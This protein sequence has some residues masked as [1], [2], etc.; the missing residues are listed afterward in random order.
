MLQQKVEG[1][2]LW[3]TG[4]MVCH[5]P[6]SLVTRE[7][8]SRLGWWTGNHSF[9]EEDRQTRFAAARSKEK[10]GAITSGFMKRIDAGMLTTIG[11]NWLTFRQS[12]TLFIIIITIPSSS[13]LS[14]SY[15][16][17]MVIGIG[18]RTMTVSGAFFLLS[19][20][21]ALTFILLCLFFHRDG[22]LAHWGETNSQ[23]HK[24]FTCGWRQWFKTSLHKIGIKWK[25]LLLQ[26]WEG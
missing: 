23:E 12:E 15:R 20:L 11:R 13:S 14:S 16:H 26:L 5:Y 25:H 10:L 19:C 1:F 4:S 22:L 3:A 6:R 21:G 2:L 7:P 8:Q 24:Y 17:R 9:S 18:W